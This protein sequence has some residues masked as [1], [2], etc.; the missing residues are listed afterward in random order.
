MSSPHHPPTSTQHQTKPPTHTPPPHP[1]PPPLRPPPPPPVIIETPK[2][3]DS[4]GRAHN[5]APDESPPQ[6]PCITPH[7]HYIVCHPVG[8]E[9]GRPGAGA[10]LP[11]AAL[12]SLLSAIRKGQTRALT[13]HCRQN[14]RARSRFVRN[15]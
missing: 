3:R 14:L 8:F 11:R 4:P 1:P 5:T 6:L 12:S 2:S 10:R 15:G 7:L 9:E 13:T